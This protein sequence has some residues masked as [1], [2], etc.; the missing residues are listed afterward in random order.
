MAVNGFTAVKDANA[1]KGSPARLKGYPKKSL[2]TGGNGI[3]HKPHFKYFTT[4]CYSL[5]KN[6]VITKYFHMFRP[7]HNKLFGSPKK[8]KSTALMLSSGH[9][10]FVGKTVD[11]VTFQIMNF[12]TCSLEISFLCVIYSVFGWK[13]NYRTRLCFP[14]LLQ[15]IGQ[16]ERYRHPP[17]HRQF[18][19][20]K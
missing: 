16:V 11:N 1:S 19:P 17:V 2:W 4:I 20:V 3:G 8:A 9:P 5:L 10:Y 12:S 7:I 14:N 13:K 15:E 6:C 18:Y